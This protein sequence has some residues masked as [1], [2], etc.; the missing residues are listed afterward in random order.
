MD[1]T[2][3]TFRIGPKDGAWE[4]ASYNIRTPDGRE[5]GRWRRVLRKHP[6]GLTVISHYTAPP[7]KAWKII[8]KASELGEEV[9]IFEGA[10]YEARGRILAWQGTFMFNAPGARHGGVSCDLTL[11]IH[12]CSGEPDEIV[13]IDLIDSEPQEQPSPLPRQLPDFLG[14]P[15]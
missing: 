1:A 14:V 10:Y 15:V 12:C 11:Y 9:L 4:P 13:S 6:H 8:G 3:K 2:W 5:Y 7:G